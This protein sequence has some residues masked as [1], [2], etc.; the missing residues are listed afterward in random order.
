MA[1]IL[2][3][4]SEHGDAYLLYILVFTIC[5]QEFVL[6]DVSWVSG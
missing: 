1:P 5:C 6:V 3:V 2:E 4:V